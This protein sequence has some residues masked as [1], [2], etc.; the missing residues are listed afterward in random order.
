MT[1]KGKGGRPKRSDTLPLVQ[2]E[3][4]KHI[5]AGVPFKYACEAVGIPYH[6]YSEWVRKGKRQS[7][8]QYHDFY[9]EVKKARG[10]A[11]SRNVAIIQKAAEKQWQAAAWW[12]ERVCPDEFGRP[13]RVDKSTGNENHNVRITIENPNVK[14]PGSVAALSEADKEGDDDE[15]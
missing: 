1:V 13:Y 4:L 2:E 3:L 6:T 8:G 9:E 10:R 11:I 5:R 7:R 12:L 14:K 15:S